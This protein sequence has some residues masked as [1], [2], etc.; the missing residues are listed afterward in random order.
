MAHFAVA[1]AVNGSSVTW[2]E[3][4]SDDEYEKG[5]LAD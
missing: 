3:K 5:S 4:P 2:M 1:E